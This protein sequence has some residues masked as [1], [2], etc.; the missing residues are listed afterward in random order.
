MAHALAEPLPTIAPLLS[1]VVPNYNHAAF[2]PEALNAIRR[3]SWQSKEL[4]VLDDAST[5]GSGETLRAMQGYDR[6]LRVIYKEK[7]EGTVAAMNQGLAAA[8]GQ[9]ICFAAADDRVMP[10]F[11]KT[12]MEMLLKHPSAGLCSGLSTLIDPSGRHMGRFRAPV[13]NGE[14][15]YLSP[16][17]ARALLIR[18][19]P[20][21]MGNTSIFRRDLLIAFGGFRPEMGSYTDGFAS[22]VMA[23]DAGA[24]FIPRSFSA[25]RR[26]ES[27][28]AATSG[29]NLER[30]D[31]IATHARAVLEDEYSHL[32]DPEFLDAWESRWRFGVLAAF[33]LVSDAAPRSIE[34]FETRLSSA[35]ARAVQRLCQGGVIG[36][37]LALVLLYARLRP[38]DA[39]TSPLLRV[40]DAARVWRSRVAGWFADSEAMPAGSHDLTVIIGRL[41]TGGA[42]SQLL[43]LLPGLLIRG[44]S[45][46]VL[47]LANEGELAAAM[48]A[49]GVCVRAPTGARLVAPF[50][51]P[52]RRILTLPL[53]VVHLWRELRARRG[54]ILNFVLPEA[55]IIGMVVAMLCRSDGVLVMSRRSLNRYQ[56]RYPLISWFERLLHRR[57]N[58]A[59]A[60]NAMAREELAREGIPAGRIKHVPNGVDLGRFAASPERR[61]ARKSLD[62]PEDA[63][64]IVVVA[65]LIPY[66]GHRVLLDALAVVGDDMP[67]V[68]RL[69]C[70]GR[71]C[72]IGTALRAQSQRLELDDNVVWLGL[73][74]NIPEL[75]AAADIGIL[76]SLEEGMPNA[77]LEYMAAAL[78]AVATDVGGVREVVE[79][80]VTGV[81]VPPDDSAVLGRAIADI[82]TD[83]AQRDAMGTAGRRRAESHFGME[84]CIE[85]YDRLFVSILEA[86]VGRQ[87]RS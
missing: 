67:T 30:A 34:S 50:P 62:L 85:A 27:G 82:A 13:P 1:V 23:L 19:G 86:G 56:R 21:F 35:D 87:A 7:N 64:V 8:R 71:D 44:W 66:K 4:I 22:I 60:N 37:R 58:F 59:V 77:V 15:C 16:P 61:A 69:L 9:Y 5:D 45:V 20:W 31:E 6:T 38:R 36:R 17:Q 51:Q 32:I 84:R 72:G 18:R 12:A 76:P 48:R 80:G 47:T 54:G 55:Y 79:H 28:L 49:R 78:P 11:F 42:E 73:R 63:F 40:A 41:D 57:V 68:W 39:L 81:L 52:A 65:N 3:Q 75:L 70:V 25:W 53:A 46:T 10:G 74:N 83:A 14:P 2:L 33:L 26:M 43:R 24:C 29:S